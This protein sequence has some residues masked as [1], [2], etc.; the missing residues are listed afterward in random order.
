MSK[1]E[2][3]FK[4]VEIDLNYGTLELCAK[5]KNAI[6]IGKNDSENKEE[7]MSVSTEEARW[8]AEKLVE[9]ANMVDEVKNALPDTFYFTIATDP[10]NSVRKC[11]KKN[12]NL[13]IVYWNY[14]TQNVPFYLSEV[15]ERLAK[16]AWKIIETEVK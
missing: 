15:K 13:H 9:F 11:V 12:D 16:G 7:Y 2:E 5:Y 14:D 10:S 8:M 1:Y 6:L 3:M 4:G